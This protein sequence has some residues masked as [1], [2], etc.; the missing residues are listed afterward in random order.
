MC[1]SS[2]SRWPLWDLERRSSGDVSVLL[3]VTTLL[4]VVLGSVALVTVSTTALSRSGD[5]VV[6]AQALYAADT[7]LER[8]LHD[9]AWSDPLKP[10]CSRLLDE[11]LPG[12][13]TYALVVQSDLKTCP[14]LQEL[15]KGLSVLCF[16]AT[17]SARGGVVQRRVSNDLRA[18]GSSATCPR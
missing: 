15:Q 8:G 4:I 13:A 9:Y 12:G 11:P 17:G 1:R 5:V 10:I 14:S 6:S 16:D 18:S 2:G 7:G 3:L